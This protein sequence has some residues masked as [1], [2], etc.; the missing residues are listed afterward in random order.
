MTRATEGF[1]F[2][3]LAKQ[4]DKVRAS[5]FRKVTDRQPTRFAGFATVPMQNSAAGANEVDQVIFNGKMGR[6]DLRELGAT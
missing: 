2:P 1:W 3:S 6:D 5:R 4:D